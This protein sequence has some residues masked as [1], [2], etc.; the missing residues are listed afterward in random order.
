MMVVATCAGCNAKI[1]GGGAAGGTGAPP[2]GFIFPMFGVGG[3]P[4]CRL[5]QTMVDCSQ[6]SSALE[7]RKECLSAL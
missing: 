3:S 1:I 2:G 6:S 7:C 4:C 5:E